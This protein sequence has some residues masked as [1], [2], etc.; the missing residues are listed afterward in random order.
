MYT[1]YSK[2]TLRVYVGTVSSVNETT[3]NGK[4]AIV[5]TLKDY[6]GEEKAIWFS[7]SDDGIKPNRADN[8]KKLNLS[9]NQFVAVVA[10]TKDDSSLSATG[11]RVIVSGKSSFDGFNVV[12]STALVTDAE[13]KDN[14]FAVKVPVDEY[15]NNN[16]ITN[17]YRVTFWNSDDGTKMRADKAVRVLNGRNKVKVALLCGRAN[18]HEHEGKTYYS[19]T[20]YTIVREPD[21]E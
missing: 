10:Y 2:D 20:G 19:M 14:K 16:K 21:R 5:V 13:V 17:W 12:V 11:I 3:R 8:V 18:T 6:S 9:V 7:N 1:I 15:I 4:L